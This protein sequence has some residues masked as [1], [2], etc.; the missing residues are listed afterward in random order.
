MIAPNVE[1][2][3]EAAGQIG[4]LPISLA[5]AQLRELGA[6]GAER[7]KE[8]GAAGLSV[9][10]QIGYQLGLQTARSILAGSAVLALAGV[11]PSDVL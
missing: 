8:I 10:F 1:M 11:K 7:A 9:D 4:Q 6:F 3:E 2:I 5:G